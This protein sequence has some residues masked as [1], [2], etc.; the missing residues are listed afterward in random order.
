MFSTYKKNGENLYMN[1]LLTLKILSVGKVMLNVAP[2][3][4]LAL[5]NTLH[6]AEI[7]KKNLV[8]DSFKKPPTLDNIVQLIT[9]LIFLYLTISFTLNIFLY[10]IFYFNVLSIIYILFLTIK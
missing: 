4:P 7:K 5:N 3:K 2:E 9:P 10:N 1:N 6:I 8:S